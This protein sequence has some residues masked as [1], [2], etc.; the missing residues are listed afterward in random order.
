MTQ[1]NLS[2][3]LAVEIGTAGV[4]NR[5]YQ[6][7]IEAERIT[8]GFRAPLVAQK[9]QRDIEDLPLFGGE[10]QQEMF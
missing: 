10:R 3:T 1:P 4:T 2:A 7:R 8:I 9:P 6:T 5:E